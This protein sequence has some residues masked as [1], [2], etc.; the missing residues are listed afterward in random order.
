MRDHAKMRPYRP[1]TR[2]R[3]ARPGR[4]YPTGRWGLACSLLLVL[5][6]AMAV[7]MFLL[8]TTLVSGYL[9]LREARRVSQIAMRTPWPTFTPDVMAS[10][11]AVAQ[12]EADAQAGPPDTAPALVVPTATSQAPAQVPVLAPAVATPLPPTFTP[13]AVVPP[14]SDQ[15]AALAASLPATP[16]PAA[17][18]PPPPPPPPPAADSGPAVEAGWTFAGTRVETQ[19]A[20]KLMLVFGELVNN[21]G[22]NQKVSQV[23]ASFFDGQGNL[24]MADKGATGLWPTRVIA[25][26][27]RVPFALTIRGVVEAASFELAVDAQT[28]DNSPRQDFEFLGINERSAGSQFCLT[29]GLHNPQAET[30]RSVVVA[31]I[32]YDAQGNLLRFGTDV[33][34]V[35]EAGQSANFA[36]CLN[37]LPENP[38]RYEV[39]AWDS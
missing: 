31:A 7:L 14:G 6:P 36:V 15:P 2:N 8:L 10:S 3:L 27:E 20:R 35:V 29:G 26:G 11:P 12:A 38:T 39:R 23:K 17:A 28:V 37:S 33:V 25:A 34:A 16:T 30:A 22:A 18:N 5:I 1:A 24:L 9:G 19:P 4:A 21:T 13:A 32:L